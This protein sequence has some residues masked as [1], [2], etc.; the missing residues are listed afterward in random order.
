[1]CL[2]LRAPVNVGDPPGTPC[3]ALMPTGNPTVP[4]AIVQTSVHIHTTVTYGFFAASDAALPTIDAGE[5][6]ALSITDW[7]TGVEK[8][9]I[10]MH[11]ATAAPDILSKTLSFHST[12]P[13]ASQV[14]SIL[15]WDADGNK[16]SGSLLPV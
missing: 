16:I 8:A 4:A 15:R 10:I 2:P 6:G 11:D 14:V 1:M 3:D 13:A 12:L 5:D 7:G 9:V